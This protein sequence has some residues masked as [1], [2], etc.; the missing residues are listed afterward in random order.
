MVR[1]HEVKLPDELGGQ[2][3]QTS[4]CGASIH[5]VCKVGMAAEGPEMLRLHTRATKSLNMCV[6][7]WGK[8]RSNSVRMLLMAEGTNEVGQVSRQWALLTRAWFSPKWQLWSLCQADGADAP[9]L[10]LPCVVRLGCE[11]T[12]LC[13]KQLSPTIRTGD[14]LATAIARGSLGGDFQ[15]FEVSY[16]MPADEP[17]LLTMLVTKL[18]AIDLSALSKR[19]QR[20]QPLSDLRALGQQAPAFAR[21]RG[22]KR[23]RA[24]AVPKNLPSD[25]RPPLVDAP[26]GI[27]SHGSRLEDIATV[28][29]AASA[30]M[31]PQPLIGGDEVP[32]DAFDGFEADDLEEIIAA[33]V[34][35]IDKGDRLESEGLEALGAEE[36]QPMGH[37]HDLLAVVSDI[38]PGAS[39]DADLP[40]GV[41]QA[42]GQLSERR[43]E[44]SSSSVVGAEAAEPMVV[45]PPLQADDPLAVVKGPS[46]GGY[47]R[48]SLSERAI[49]RISPVFNKSVSVKCYAH[50]KC[51]V[52]MAEWKLPSRAVLAKW[53]LEALP[54]GNTPDERRAVA[55]AHMAALKAEVAR[56]T[57]PG[58]ER[59]AL[60]DEAT[61]TAPEG[62]V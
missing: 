40:E 16:T 47:F 29:P 36:S 32:I 37:E 45:Q 44:A 10:R 48:H 53:L 21:G 31:E 18:E 61:R 50:A 22:S 24:T 54:D 39:G 15:F 33:H 52:A 2:G 17:T 43:V 26:S 49:G 56:S 4:C 20:N 5:P 7:R 41:G 12:R 42:D 28:G 13:P 38:V 6:D 60:I 8:D 46:S 34:D 62:N 35:Y 1:H 3:L 30:D 51:Q 14:E 9:V 25:G 11:P 23:T 57:P 58:R 19:P 59:Q 27:A 55:Q